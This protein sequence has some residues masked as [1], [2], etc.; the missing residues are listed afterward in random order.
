[1]GEHNQSDIVTE[2]LEKLSTHLSFVENVRQI[3]LDDSSQEKVTIVENATILL[4][5]VTNFLRISLIYLNKNFWRKA[6][7]TIIGKD[8]V[9]KSKEELDNAVDAF[10]RSVSRGADLARWRTQQAEENEKILSSF[11]D[12]DFEIVQKEVRS[13]RL[14]GTGEWIFREPKF[15]KWLNKDISVLWCPGIRTFSFALINLSHS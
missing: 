13:K 10:D 8:D 15:D 4:A 7:E 2:Q 1:M 3:N 6:G 12:M 14:P 11:S 5:A 9:T